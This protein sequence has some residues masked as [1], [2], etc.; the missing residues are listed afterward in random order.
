MP[1]EI[2]DRRAADNEYLHKDFHGALSTGIQYLDE[3]Y[4][5]DAV[6]EY[7][8]QFARSYYAPLI[9][10]IADRGLIALKEHFDKLYAIEGGDVRVKFSEDELVLEVK[11]CPA[12]SHMRAN[13]YSIARLFHETTRTVNE[14][15]CEGT[16]YAAELVEYDKET[17]RS[18]QRFYRRAK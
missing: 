16:P 3:H 11:A 12:V 9:A 14:A 1:K 2:M 13:G 5:E 10:D 8:W 7:L 17:G 15:L 4:G 6:R 18:V